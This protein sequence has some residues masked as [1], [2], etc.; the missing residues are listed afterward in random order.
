MLQ[1]LVLESEKIG[2][3]VHF[4][5]TKIL[6]NGIG[7]GMKSAEVVLGDKVVEVLRLKMPL[8]L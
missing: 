8:L 6:S 1:D 7:P 2:L 3:Q 4:G 5:K